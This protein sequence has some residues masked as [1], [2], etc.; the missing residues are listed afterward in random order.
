MAKKK[1][2]SRERTTVGKENDVLSL[3]LEKKGIKI[4]SS[5]EMTDDMNLL[6]RL[7]KIM[8]KE[9][10][11]EERECDKCREVRKAQNF[12]TIEYG[13][14]SDDHETI[15]KE[16]FWIKYATHCW[17]CDKGKTTFWKSSEGTP[18]ITT[19]WNDLPRSVDYRNAHSA[20][21]TKHD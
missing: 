20:R 9:G 2:V 12:I 7:I 15:C 5:P 18:I 6:V 10:K 4:E 16:C 11:E 14:Y 19:D 1:H 21:C 8:Q 17:E 13:I 3:T